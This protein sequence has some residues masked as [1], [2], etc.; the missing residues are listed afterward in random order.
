[1]GQFS[2]STE[3]AQPKQHDVLDNVVIRPDFYQHW[4]DALGQFAGMMRL[5]KGMN[6]VVNIEKEKGYISAEGELTLVVGVSDET[7]QMAFPAGTWDW[8][9]VEAV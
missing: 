7:L 6:F 1:M 5:Q 9:V 8:K 4:F 2:K 3:A